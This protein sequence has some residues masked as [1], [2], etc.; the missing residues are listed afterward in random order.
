MNS[1]IK[2]NN[3]YLQNG[4]ESCINIKNKNSCVRRWDCSFNNNT[5]NTKCNLNTNEKLCN[6]HTDCNWTN[7]SCVNK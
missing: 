3:Y 7:S 5:C 6:E 2:N 1:F 4:G